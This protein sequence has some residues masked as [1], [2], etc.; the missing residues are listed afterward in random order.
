[1]TPLG[2]AAT[3]RGR[4]A[5]APRE[6]LQN[7]PVALRALRPRTRFAFC[8]RSAHFES[9]SGHEDLICDLRPR[10]PLERTTLLE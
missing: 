7:G 2:Q 4:R 6:V 8:G 9:L 3:L 1:M 10:V 5:A